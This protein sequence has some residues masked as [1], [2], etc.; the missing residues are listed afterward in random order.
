M[1][2]HEQAEF[3]AF[4]SVR[5]E[6][7]RETAYLI[8][9]SWPVADQVVGRA[10]SGLLPRWRRLQRRDETDARARKA[11]VRA[12]LAA[13][14]TETPD[15]RLAG[16]SREQRAAL[17][18][19]LRERLSVADSADLLGIE[20]G[21]VTK[22]TAEGLAV[23]G[24][25][26]EEM[27][28]LLDRLAGEG[29]EATLDAFSVRVRGTRAVRRRQL[30]AGS[31]AIVLLAVLVV[32]LRPGSSAQAKNS[33]SAQAALTPGSGSNANVAVVAWLP[34][35]TNAQVA[36]SQ[37]K[38][39]DVLLAA[40]GKWG[41]VLSSRPPSMHEV[42]QGQGFEMAHSS[43]VVYAV[44]AN[45][46]EVTLRAQD[47]TAFGGEHE[48]VVESA[49]KCSGPR[50]PAR[51]CV[52]SAL[53][54]GVV[55]WTW[56]NMIDG[57]SVAPAGNP[58]HQKFLP[59]DRSAVVFGADGSTLSATL[60]PFAGVAGDPNSKLLGLTT[61]PSPNDAELGRLALAAAAAWQGSVPDLSVSSAPPLPS[62][63]VVTLGPP[64]ASA[65]AAT[66]R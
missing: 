17:V 12:A 61:V 45:S 3:E 6:R 54:R 31:G 19:R 53:P 14:V 59:F 22:A 64:R 1:R 49:Q 41:K 16:V 58:S 35:E 52:R 44:G 7:L 26:A 25:Q 37:S 30:V 48:S 36:A 33:T 40:A 28:D 46:V 55:L 43:S 20:E 62:A 39:F 21:A 47:P 5:G 4:V 23:L 63:P 66:S 15:P 29:P 38:A 56:E 2:P 9:A 27:R 57:A 65:F 60:T 8:C 50:D 34:F 24:G 51:S 11:V 18:L 13:E 32:L 10:L 42:Q